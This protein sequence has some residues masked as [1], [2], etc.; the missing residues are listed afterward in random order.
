MTPAESGA[1]PPAPE[2]EKLPGALWLLALGALP[3]AAAGIG[4]LLWMVLPAAY[5]GV[6]MRG[7]QAMPAVIES[8][9]LH[10]HR[11]SKGGTTRSVSVQ[12]RYTVNGVTFVG[13][14]AAVHTR[15]DNIGSFQERLGQRLESAAQSGEPVPV[16]V[17]PRNPAESVVDR[18]LRPE[19]LALGLLLATLSGG[20]GLWVLARIAR[21][22]WR[23]RLDPAPG[24]AG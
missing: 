17:N 8:A 7:W 20:L 4:I 11:S 12:Y 3:F 1:R 16:W 22:V 21:A 14:R 13:Q 10:S 5:D 2:R 24:A 6:R 23:G 19:L 15:P 18:S 9:T